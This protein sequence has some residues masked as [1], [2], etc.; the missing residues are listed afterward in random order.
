MSD[1]SVAAFLALVNGTRG[2]FLLESGHHGALWLDL[3]GLFT[4]ADRI[5]PFVDELAA[6]IVPHD[7]EMICGP[8][9]G[10]AF[11]AQ[12]VAQK[13]ALPFCFT[14]RVMPSNAE[15]LYRAAYVLPA[16]FRPRVSGLRVA[17][18]DDVI[19]AGSALRGTLNELKSCDAHVVVAGALLQ[20]GDVG[21]THLEREDVLVASVARDDY[22]LWLP[23]EC[24]LCASGTPLTSPSAQP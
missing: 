4:R 1:T 18:V 23:T 17:I 10:G 22:T 5:A 13:L 15:G 7:A 9:L 14:E 24:P 21:A 19:S 11:L 16:V 8:L 3:D 6:R 12:L 20:L 2:H